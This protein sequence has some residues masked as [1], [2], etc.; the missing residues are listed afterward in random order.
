RGHRRRWRARERARRQVRSRVV[1]MRVGSDMTISWSRRAT[2]AVKRLTGVVSGRRVR[3]LFDT[4]AG[5]G[6]RLGGYGE[7][8]EVRSWSAAPSAS[9]CAW[10]CWVAL[11]SLS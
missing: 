2:I 11:A 5:D 3:P 8:Q 4:V 7:S 1:E 6:L 9:A 10:A